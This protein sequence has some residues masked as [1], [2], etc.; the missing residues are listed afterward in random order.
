MALEDFRHRIELR[1]RWAEVDMQGVV[2][3]AH[4]LMYAD[5]CITEYW[6]AI[7]LDYPDDLTRHGSDTF[8]RKSTVDYFAAAR[9]DDELYVCGRTARIGN[10]SLRFLVEM[11]RRTETSQPLVGVELIYVN[12]DPV[13]R[14]SVPW[15][16]RIRE[17]IRAYERVPPEEDT[18]AGR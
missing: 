14:K 11:F 12:A 6:R 10:S 1:V 5:V 3:N 2:F 9:Y 17:H 15:S 13:K 7:G 16:A 8:V 18:G 4:Y